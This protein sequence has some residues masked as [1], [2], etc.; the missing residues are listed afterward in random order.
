[1]APPF[2]TRTPAAPSR[3][4]LG[5]PRASSGSLGDD[6]NSVSETTNTLG[7]PSGRLGNPPAAQT[8][9]QRPL[10]PGLH[11]FAAISRGDFGSVQS[12]VQQRP[13]VLEEDPQRF[14]DEAT[15]AYA[16]DK[17]EYGDSLIQQGVILKRL[18]SVNGEQARR[19]YF[20]MLLDKDK[21]S[22]AL[23]RHFVKFD[24][25]RKEA[26]KKAAALRDD[27]QLAS[28]GSVASQQDEPGRGTQAGYSRTQTQPS[29]SYVGQDSAQANTTR[30]PSTQ[31]TFSGQSSL[32]YHT[33]TF[34][35]DSTRAIDRQDPFVQ[36]Q[37]FE[38]MNISGSTQSPPVGVHPVVSPRPQE[39]L[40]MSTPS[41]N[42]QAGNAIPLS[43]VSG[44]STV[45]PPDTLDPRYFVHDSNFYRVGR[46][47]S[48]VWHEP[49]GDTASNVSRY[50]YTSAQ[51]PVTVGL[52]GQKIYSTIRR[53][54][55]VR[56][57]R[58]YSVC[59]QINTYAGR[60]LLKF[61]NSP[62]DVKAHSIIY[63]TGTTANYLPTEPITQKRPI[64]VDRTQ[65]G[66]KLDPASRLCYSRP[67]TVEHNVKSM[68]I[69]VVPQ[70]CLSDL[71]RYYK[72][73][74]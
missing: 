66:V 12:Y 70:E 52:H 6:V 57:G 53:M 59:I 63:M 5:G 19:E 14:F 56:Y 26:K 33:D 74:N 40:L 55:V 42:T 45:G 43:K 71:L 58:G 20:S 47:F 50:T 72:E 61:K 25:A 3:P 4:A 7:M 22:A 54:V 73:I 29:A 64:A 8:Q 39:N 13:L 36:L 65:Q 16:S 27:R 2:A 51:K 69:G 32:S 28:G 37:G 1:M 24:E 68:E 49:H 60:G 46:V 38:S 34:R 18:E 21:K 17:T 23:G 10:P 35:Q 44:T 67:H 15:R 30:Y 31:A 62:D 11:Q 48:V 9:L 41:G